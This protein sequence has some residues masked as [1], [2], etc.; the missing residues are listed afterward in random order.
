MLSKR[1]FEVI[2]PFQNV[3]LRVRQVSPQCHPWESTEIDVLFYGHAPFQ[4]IDLR[5][6]QGSPQ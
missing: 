1:S 3:Y 5:V 4:N 6:R 2:T